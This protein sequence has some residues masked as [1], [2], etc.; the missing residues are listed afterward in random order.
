[1]KICALFGHR[2]CPA[3]VRPL[4]RQLLRELVER[5]EA[6]LFYL[7]NQG[8]F[9]AMARGVLEELAAEDP[10]VDFRVVLAYLPPPG[11]EPD[12]RSLFPE[13]IEEVPPRFAILWRD[14]WMV[15]RASLAAAYAV[16]PWGGA[17]E[18]VRRARRQGT[19]VY[20]IPPPAPSG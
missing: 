12:P 16:R 19:R 2:D 20:I 7:G 4:L 9:D 3:W 14:R 18:A 15:D 10:R 11:R 1:M 5:G 17:A 8:G 6:E 13:G